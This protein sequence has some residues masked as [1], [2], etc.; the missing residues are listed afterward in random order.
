MKNYQY[1]TIIGLLFM[2]L[3]RQ[4]Q[5]EGWKIAQSLLGSIL[6]IIAI[7]QAIKSE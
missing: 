3:S 1:Y 7:F 4:E 2:I 6:M 5:I